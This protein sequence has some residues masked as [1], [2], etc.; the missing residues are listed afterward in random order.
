MVVRGEEVQNAD[1]P[2]RVAG[3]DEAGRALG[4]H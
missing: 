1:M 2:Q 3:L 4:F